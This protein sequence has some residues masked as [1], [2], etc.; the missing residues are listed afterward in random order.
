[1]TP[2][3]KLHKSKDNNYPKNMEKVWILLRLTNL[4]QNE[5][6]PIKYWSLYSNKSC[7][8]G[9]M[10]LTNQSMCKNH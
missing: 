6:I 9:I 4:C 1:M 2:V 10:K 5:T 7:D 3:Q 8:S